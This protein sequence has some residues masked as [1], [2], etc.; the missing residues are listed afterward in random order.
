MGSSLPSQDGQT[1][2]TGRLEVGRCQLQGGGYVLR[3]ER[4]IVTKIFSCKPFSEIKI[5]VDHKKEYMRL[6]TSESPRVSDP[7]IGSFRS[8]APKREYI[9][10]HLPSHGV[11]ESWALNQ[12]SSAS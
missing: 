10:P 7:N 6:Q 8:R 5:H 1:E 2:R 12:G 9:P 3:G 4:N 11:I